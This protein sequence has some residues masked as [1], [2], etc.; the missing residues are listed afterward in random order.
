MKTLE[1]LDHFTALYV[2]DNLCEKDKCYLYMK[3]G[4]VA[5]WEMAKFTW[6]FQPDT[7]EGILFL[8][9][10]EERLKASGEKE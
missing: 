8:E 7:T 9:E 6:Y 10:Y 4:M 1:E 5:S 3:Y 2:Y